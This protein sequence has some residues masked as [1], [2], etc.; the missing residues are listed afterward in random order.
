MAHSCEEHLHL[1][2]CGVLRF[3]EDDCCVVECSSAHVC[4]WDDLD[5]VCCDESLYCCEVHHVVECVEEWSEVWVDFF[6]ESSREEAEAFARFDGWAYEDNFSCESDFEEVYG[7]GDG[8]VCFSCSGRSDAEDDVVVSDGVEVVSLCW[9]FGCEPAA[10]GVDVEVVCPVFFEGS[11]GVVVGWV[12][13]VVV[14][15][16]VGVGGWGGD[17]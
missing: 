8:E 3:V 9:C 14:I 17:G 4:E 15:V 10:G 6:C 1:S 7:C 11:W 2:L 16:V 12:A 13:V 5:D